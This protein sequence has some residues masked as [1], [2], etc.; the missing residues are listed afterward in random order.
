MTQPLPAPLKPSDAHIRAMRTAVQGLLVDVASAVLLAV[1]PALV[2]S[3]FAWSRAYWGAL[4]LLAAKTAIQTGVA[5][6]MA[7]VLPVR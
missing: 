4:G 7:K 5:Y 2:G 1:G 6:A 3:S